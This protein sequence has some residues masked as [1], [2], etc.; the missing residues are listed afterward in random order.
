MTHAA[1]TVGST[2]SSAALPSQGEQLTESTC[3]GGA[4]D[5]RDE[6]ANF[7][8]DASAQVVDF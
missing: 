5:A 4:S 7:G 8:M 2:S 3:S 1:H 6:E